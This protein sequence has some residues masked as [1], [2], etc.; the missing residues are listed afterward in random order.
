MFRILFGIAVLTGGAGLA[1]ADNA[2]AGNPFAQYSDPDSVVAAVQTTFEAKAGK[3]VRLSVY[4]SDDRFLEVA[5]IKHQ[6]ALNESGLALVKFYG[7]KP[8]AYA[9][10]AYL[11]ENDDGRLNRGALGIPTEPVAFSNGVVPK[12]RRPEFE[13]TKVDVAPGSVVVITLQD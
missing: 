11:D 1:R 2:P 13:E 8:G 12:L 7:L 9:F 5:A 10:A 4:D 6:G 3:A